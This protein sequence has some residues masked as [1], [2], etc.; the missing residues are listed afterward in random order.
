MRIS[1]NKEQGVHMKRTL[2]VAG[3]IG[4]VGLG[5][6]TAVPASADTSTDVGCSP[7]ILCTIRDTPGNAV[8]GITGTPERFVNGITSTP[9]RAA[10]GIAGTPGRFVGGIASTPGNFISG[11]ASTPARFFGGIAA[12]PTR[13]T[14]GINKVLGPV[15]PPPAE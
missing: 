10:A 7:A 1:K 3:S 14:D 13:L 15:P 4:F 6:L 9:G 2:M 8:N 5:L 12:T 11:I